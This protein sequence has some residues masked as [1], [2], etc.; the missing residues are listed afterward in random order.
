MEIIKDNSIDNNEIKVKEEVMK[1]YNS[2]GNYWGEQTS[3]QR[4]FK[5]GIFSCLYDR[6]YKKIKWYFFFYV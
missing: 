3:I 2:W 1:Y 4:I 6:R 5:Q